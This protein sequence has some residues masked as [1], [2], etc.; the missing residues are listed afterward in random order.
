VYTRRRTAVE[1]ETAAARL[2]TVAFDGK[3]VTSELARLLDRGVGG[4]VLFARN[5]GTAAEV[6][7]L[8]RAI[9]RRAARPLLVSIDQEGGPVARLRRGFTSVPAMRVVGRANDAELARELGALIGR[10]LRA[11]G[12]DLDYAPVLDVDTNPDNPV[13]GERSLSADPARVAE[14]GIALAA[15]LVSAGVAACGKHFP[16]HGDTTTDSHH[17]LPRLPHGL[18]RLERVELVPFRAASAAGIPALMTAHVVFEALDPNLPATMNRDVIHGFLREKLGYD[19]VVV[20]DDLEMKAIAAHFPIAEVV[21]RGLLAGVDSFLCCHRESLAHEAI[22]E[23]VRSSEEGRVPA[24]RVSEAL[25]RVEQ[26]TDRFARGP[27]EPGELQLLDCDAHR[28]L[29]ARIEEHAA[30]RSRP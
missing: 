21:T 18:E 24:S 8:T 7:E 10:E 9:K 13:I 30:E 16:G 2:V 29:V 28:A 22:D 17:E 11:V 1:L 19:G 4:V 5:V 12:V 26:L 23:I 15:G 25:S 20:T 14:L 6:L 3:S 27:D